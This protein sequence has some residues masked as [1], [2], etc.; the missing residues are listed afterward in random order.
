MPDKE[1]THTSTAVR[2]STYKVIQVI[3]E[4]P[5]LLMYTSVPINAFIAG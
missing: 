1:L 4:M 5:Y 2:K 3:R